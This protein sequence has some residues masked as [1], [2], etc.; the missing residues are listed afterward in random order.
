MVRHF[1]LGLFGDDRGATAVEYGLLLGLMV[2]AIIG[3][4]TAVGT[5]TTNNFNAA[6]EAYNT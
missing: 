2:I 4:I 5:Q 6:A 3:G 1:F